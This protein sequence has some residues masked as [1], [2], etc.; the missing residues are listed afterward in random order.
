MMVSLPLVQIM[1]EIVINNNNN[2][3][4]VYRFHESTKMVTN[5]CTPLAPPQGGGRG[6]S[7]INVMGR[8]GPTEPNILHPKKYMDLILCMHTQKNTRL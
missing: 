2:S 5:F 6:Q 7:G 8:G 3:L 4:I 1:K